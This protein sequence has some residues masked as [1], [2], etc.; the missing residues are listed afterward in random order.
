MWSKY[1][2][3]RE[4]IGVTTAC[5]RVAWVLELVLGHTLVVT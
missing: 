2:Y 5:S 3:P 4:L 1:I